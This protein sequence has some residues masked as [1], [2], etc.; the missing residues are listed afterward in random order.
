LSREKA[1]RYVRRSLWDRDLRIDL[2]A[3]QAFGA[4]ALV[5]LMESKELVEANLSANLLASLSR[6]L[7][8]EWQHLPIQDGGVP[9]ERFEDL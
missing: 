5:T 9:D 8:L 1:A 3:I 7:G 2:E 4:K 6:E